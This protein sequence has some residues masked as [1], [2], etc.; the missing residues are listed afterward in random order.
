MFP[1]NISSCRTRWSWD[2]CNATIDLN[3]CCKNGPNVEWVNTESINPDKIKL[4]VYIE[5]E[6][7][8]YSA[9]R[10]YLPELKDGS[11]S[12]DCND[13]CIF[14]RSKENCLCS[15]QSNSS[16]DYSGIHPKLLHPM[17]Q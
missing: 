3:G 7:S 12:T 15:Q 17:I 8:L 1:F 16:Y 13:C 10:K 5:R 14:I 6:S 11:L 9:I 2:S 4:K